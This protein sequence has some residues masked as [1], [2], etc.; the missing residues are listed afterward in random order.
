[1]SPRPEGHGLPSRSPVDGADT[2]SDTNQDRAPRGGRKTAKV[3]VDSPRGTGHR[4]RA[5][6][7]QSL[8]APPQHGGGYDDESDASTEVTEIHAGNGKAAA[9]EVGSE[10][11]ISDAASSAAPSSIEDTIGDGASTTGKS[12]VSSTGGTSTGCTLCGKQ[13]KIPFTVLTFMAMSVPILMLLIASII[14]MVVAT[15][16]TVLTF[17]A[18]SVPI[19][20]LLIA[21]IIPM[22]VATQDLITVESFNGLSKKVSDC[23]TAMTVEDFRMHDT[24]YHP[25]DVS[26]GAYMTARAETTVMCDSELLTELRGVAR[27]YPE[28]DSQRDTMQRAIRVLAVERALMDAEIDDHNITAQKERLKQMRDVFQDIIFRATNVIARV[29]A[30]VKSETRRYFVDL[31][32]VGVTRAKLWLAASTG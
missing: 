16:V 23:V 2:D 19:L 25:T 24:I 20:M 15:P 1:M 14:P 11:D 26:R 32:L 9:Y 10:A 31:N 28:F 5:R 6:G 8:T 27:R 13:F 29:A 18:M 22:V 30:V 17:M 7:R 21:S 3:V 4:S 12:K